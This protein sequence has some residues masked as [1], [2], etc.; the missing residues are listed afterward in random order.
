MPHSIRLAGP[1]VNTISPQDNRHAWKRQNEKVSSEP[2][3]PS[4]S[5]YIAASNDTLLCQ[6]DADLRS[7]P[8]QHGFSPVKWQ[9]ITDVEILK[10]P[11]V[12]DIEKMRT[13]TLMHAQFNM[14]NKKLG[15]DMMYNGEAHGTIAREQ[16]GCRKGLRSI[17][18]ALNKKL[19]MDLLR[20]RRQAAALASTDAK[21]CHDR[22]VHNMTSIAMQRQGAPRSA[23]LS[24]LRTL[25]NASHRICTAFGYSTQTFGRNRHPPLQGLGQGNGAASAAWVL[26]STPLF[27]ML[28]TAG[29]GLSLLSALSITLIS[30]V[31]LAFADDT[32]VIHCSRHVDTPGEELVAEMQ[33]VL[34][35]W[36]GGL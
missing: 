9:D 10:K 32:D 22:M 29:Y 12:Y 11:G 16:L 21:S 36:E 31:G 4:F 1:C 8:Y 33:P 34:D 6:F 19:S 13:I 17:F 18:A 3:A 26:L 35:L 25:Q 28:H 2:S 15:R 24:M 23:V 30:F 27:H 14:N 7:L 5:H 20:M